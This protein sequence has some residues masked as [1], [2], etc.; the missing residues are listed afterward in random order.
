MWA[1]QGRFENGRIKFIEGKWND[2]LINQLLD[3]PSP[4]AHDDLPD[5]LAYIDQLGGTLYDFECEV[6]DWE[7]IDEIAGI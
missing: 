4:L 7:P 2:H 3:F 6:D 5:A 1:L